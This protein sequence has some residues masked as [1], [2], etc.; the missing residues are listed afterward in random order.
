MRAL[1]RLPGV[2]PWTAGYVALRGLAEPDG[3]PAGD[4]ILRQQA[5]TAGI[6]LTAR[7]LDARAQLWRPF[8]GYAVMHLWQA[9]ADSP[10]HTTGKPS[11]PPRQS[12]RTLIQ[13][14]K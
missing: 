10:D 13:G 6:A 4:L 12:T 2:G 14:P 3:F 1:V 7:E 8:R 5:S 11:S 9:S